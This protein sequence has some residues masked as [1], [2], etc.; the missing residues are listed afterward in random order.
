MSITKLSERL[1]EKEEG[2]SKQASILGSLGIAGAAHV[3]QNAVTKGV[4]GRP[5]LS[6]QLASRFKDG[7]A[8]R[9]SALTSGDGVVSSIRGFVPDIGVIEDQVTN[10]GKAVRTAMKEHGL[11]PNRVTPKQWETIS[12][13]M[14]GRFRQAIPDN[15]VGA[16]VVGKLLKPILDKAGVQNTKDLGEFIRKLTDHGDGRFLADME[17]AWKSLPLTGKGIS[18]IGKELKKANIAPV[19]AKSGSEPL[20]QS[21]RRTG[22]VAGIA[23]TTALDPVTGVLNLTKRIGMANTLPAVAKKGQQGLF[24]FMVTNPSKKAFNSG[25][26][27]EKLKFEKGR[28]F[29]KDYGLNPVTSDIHTLARRLGENMDRHGIKL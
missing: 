27:G 6:K 4:M 11:D 26:A 9:S 17:K 14:Q 20:R 2:L 25:L 15:P 24:N 22:D 28:K 1:I 3:A 10:I 7:L 23:A 29:V 21:V 12:N 18:G 8:G 16:E 13:V 5:W 19:P